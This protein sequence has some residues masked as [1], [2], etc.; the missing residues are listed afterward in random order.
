MHCILCSRGTLTLV[1]R[2]SSCE[3]WII[4]TSLFCLSVVAPPR[5]ESSEYFI[6]GRRS[7]PADG[8]GVQV[9]LLLIYEIESRRRAR[10]TLGNIV[11]RKLVGCPGCLCH[12][13]DHIIPFSK[14]LYLHSR[15]A[16]APTPSCSA[17]T[18]RPCAPATSTSAT[19][20][21]AHP[22]RPAALLT[23]PL[24]LASA[25]HAALNFAQFSLGAYPPARPAFLCHLLPDFPTP[26][27]APA[28][29]S[30]RTASSSAH[31]RDRVNGGVRGSGGHA[32]DPLRP[33]GVPHRGAPRDWTGDAEM[34]RAEWGFAAE[35][36]RA[37]EEIAWW[38]ADPA[39]RNRCGAGVPPY[40]L[41]APTSGPGSPTAASLIASPFIF[42]FNFN[43]YY[44]LL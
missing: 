33:R 1:D 30:S 3:D 12:D 10:D 13:Y 34:A 42:N 8:L 15:T 9:Q 27:P 24:W 2:I 39:W 14:L 6:R 37:G 35:V 21:L 25:H 38:N 40:E 16:C 19:P 4:L 41:M 31:S 32:L 29:A 18:L 17:D 22:R 7:C 11:F 43:Y 26:A 44:L 5:H 28:P 23:T 36:R 20:R